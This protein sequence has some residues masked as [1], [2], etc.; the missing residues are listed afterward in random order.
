M[1][2][3]IVN[4]A[5]LCVTMCTRVPFNYGNA[6]VNPNLN[7]RK[8]MR[9]L[10]LCNEDIH[11]K[12]K[13]MK[14]FIVFMSRIIIKVAVKSFALFFLYESDQATNCNVHVSI[15]TRICI[16]GQV[17]TRKVNQMVM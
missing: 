9:Y 8:Y 5:K 17:V 6:L 10:R 1:V 15:A 3:S 14:G 16:L 11:C 4:D 13:K 7:L 12:L 2:R